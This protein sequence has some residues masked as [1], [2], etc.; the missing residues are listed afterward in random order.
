MAESPQMLKLGDTI[1]VW[2]LMIIGLLLMFGLFTRTAALAGF[3]LVFLFYLA[4]PPLPMQGFTVATSQGMELY[5]DKT[6]IE[7]M[8][9]LVVLSF[10]TG[11]MA[12]LDIFV[13][14]WRQRRDRY[15]SRS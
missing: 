3:G 14:Q 1:T 6:A 7:A 8:A 11:Q 15:F 4:A 13:R 10:P 9:L 2:G 12:G 5:I